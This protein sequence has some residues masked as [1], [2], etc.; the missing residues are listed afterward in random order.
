MK[1]IKPLKFKV[2]WMR[3][4]V[5]SKVQFFNLGLATSFANTLSVPAHVYNIRTFELVHTNQYCKVKFNVT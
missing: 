2:V 3:E 4:G 1:Q 5:I